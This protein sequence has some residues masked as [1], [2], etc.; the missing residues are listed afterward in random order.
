MTIV[1]TLGLHTGCIGAVF[2]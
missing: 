1:V 2:S